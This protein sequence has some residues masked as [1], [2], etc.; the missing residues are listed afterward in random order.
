MAD[1]F[2]SATVIGTDLSPT[3]P[4]GMQPSNV[5]FE[6]DDCTSEWVY[7]PNH[8][9]FV[10]I[11]G[12]FGSISEWPGLYRQAYKHLKPGAY[13]EQMEW[14]VHYRAPDGTLTPHQVFRRVADNTVK[15]GMLLGK[16]FEIAENMAGL[17]RE[18]GFVDV[19]EKRY[20][21]PVGPW[22][23]DPK[24][25]EIGR[26]N[27]LSWEE[28]AEGWLLAGYTR[29]LGVSRLNCSCLVGA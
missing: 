5:Q 2:P 9:D 3:A 15:V 27:L 24:L 29:V 10:H 22:T 18:A 16:T 28:G 4:T 14:S 25:K 11:R 20:K 12:L 23:S 8:F 26:W 1:K 17:I 13:I 6:I 19:V 21:W 7:P